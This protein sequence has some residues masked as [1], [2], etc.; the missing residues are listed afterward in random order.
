M[1]NQNYNGCGCNICDRGDYTN[2][3]D[4]YGRGCCCD[5]DFTGCG[6]CGNAAFARAAR[7]NQRI[8]TR[9]ACEDRAA[10]QYLRNMCCCRRSW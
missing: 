5:N 1:C 10:A 4:F 2:Y 6:C 8:L 9:R 3:N 7:M